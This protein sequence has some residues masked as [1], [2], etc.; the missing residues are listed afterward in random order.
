MTAEAL[1]KNSNLFSVESASV[2]GLTEGYGEKNSEYTQ[3][4]FFSQRTEMSLDKLIH[5]LIIAGTCIA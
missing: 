1:K 4:Q 2:L 5:V 3:K